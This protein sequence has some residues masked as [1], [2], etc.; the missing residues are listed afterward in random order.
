MTVDVLALER[1]HLVLARE[2]LARMR[3]GTRTL[4]ETEGTW[5]NDPLTSRALAA[6]LAR[7][8]D[9]LLDDGVTPLFFG[10]LDRSVETFHV[11]RRHVTGAD[12]EPVVVDWRAPVAES[13]YRASATNPMGLV[14]RRRFGYREGVLTAYE[15]D[16]LDRVLGTSALL[17]DDIERPRTGPMR[18]IV[19]TIQPEQD[20][21]VRA[22][23][24]QTLCVQGAPGTGKTAV[25]LHRAAYLLY[26]HRA[27]LAATGILVV[28]P[29][30]AFLSY[31]QEVLPALGEVQVTQ[32]TADDLAPRVVVRRTDSDAT[33]VVKGDARMAV[34]LAKLLWDGTSRATEPLM[35]AVGARRYRVW[36]EEVRELERAVRGRGLAWGTGRAALAGGLASL[37]VRQMDEDGRSVSERAVETLARSKGVTAYVDA[38]W[39]PVTASALV[40]R[41]LSSPEDLAR[42]ADGVLSPAAQ[43][44]LIRGRPGA[45]PSWSRADLALLDEA[46]DLLE[47]TTGFAHVVLDEAQDLSAMQLRAV[48]RRC[49]SGSATVLGDLAQAT[50]PWATGTWQQVLTHLGKPDGEVQ[51]LTTGYRVPREVLDHADRLLPTIAPGLPASASLRSVPGSLRVQAAADLVAAC[52]EVV[53]ARVGQGSTA[54]VALGDGLLGSVREALA[55]AGVPALLLADTGPSSTVT[56]VPAQA[57]KGLEFDHVV[58]LEPADLA[59]VGQHGLRLLYVAL[60]R[61]VSS[62]VVLH[63]RPLPPELDGPSAVAVGDQP[64]AEH[65][66]T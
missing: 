18:D 46:A 20:V 2:Q 56:L 12:G 54:V 61:A 1:A 64:A 13:F 30:R 26:A 53:L 33:A 60:T 7:R 4:L 19:A 29:N 35:H 37:L 62:L 43:A 36:P 16:R 24:D 10:R 57:V 31:V 66:H 49:R 3:E 52:V 25:G 40:G 34:V 5:G 50:T 32:V 45:R 6:T 22:P 11:G 15:D 8:H 39:P 27:R 65:N 21:L 9:Q 44:L 41:L 28:G 63:R 23:L 55:V 59:A 14:L 47:R 48:G 51:A 42:A 38:L 17:V 58:L